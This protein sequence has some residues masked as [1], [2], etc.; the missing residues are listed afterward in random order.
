MRNPVPLASDVEATGGDTMRRNLE[1][2]T[3]FTRPLN[4]LGLPGLV[5]PSGLD[6]NGV[7][8]SIQLIAAPR[9]E[10]LLLRLGDAF[11]REAGFNRIRPR[12]L[13]HA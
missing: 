13:E 9:R 12:L 11:E 4:F 3:A 5:T 2:L 1:A 7:P 8:L 6:G 10:A